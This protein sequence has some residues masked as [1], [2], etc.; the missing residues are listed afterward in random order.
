MVFS[1]LGR[2]TT[3]GR[4]F[5][6][7]GQPPSCLRYP[8]FSSVNYWTTSAALILSNFHLELGPYRLVQSFSKFL[9]LAL[10]THGTVTI[11]WM[12]S[13]LYTERAVCLLSEVTFP[14]RGVSPVLP[15]AM[16]LLGAPPLSLSMYI[17]TLLSLFMY[18]SPVSSA[19]VTA[20]GVYFT[21]KML[22]TCL[23][24]LLLLLLLKEYILGT[25]ILSR[26]NRF[27]WDSIKQL[28]VLWRP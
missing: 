21:Y 18:R 28:N 15:P 16:D 13:Y 24:L 27:H 23:L 14:Q 22:C 6:R 2:S 9:N 7:A 11:S 8:S 3:L 10:T 26:N 25:A 17:C 1:Y 5:W 12:L 20:R 4:R 19:K